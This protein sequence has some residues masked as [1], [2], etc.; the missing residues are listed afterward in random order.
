[1]LGSGCERR[2]VGGERSTAHREH[3]WRAERGAASLCSPGFSDPDSPDD[4]TVEAEEAE[5][6]LEAM[7]PGA[8]VQRLRQRQMQVAGPSQV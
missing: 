5:V 7:L 1:M 4:S 3:A 2:R 6:L 8:I